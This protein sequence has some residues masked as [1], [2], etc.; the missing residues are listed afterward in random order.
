[1]ND[2]LRVRTPHNAGSAWW[3]EEKYGISIYTKKSNVPI[4]IRWSVLLSAW[5]RRAKIKEAERHMRT[6]NAKRRKASIAKSNC[7]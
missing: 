1:M 3:Y 7:V 4:E 2:E 6:T 5:K